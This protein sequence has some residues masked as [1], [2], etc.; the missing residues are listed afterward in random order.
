MNEDTF[1]DD[2]VDM[3]ELA[4]VRPSWDEAAALNIEGDDHR[5]NREGCTEPHDTWAASELYNELYTE[6]S[7]IEDLGQYKKILVVGAGPSLTTAVAEAI[8]YSD[9]DAILLTLPVVKSFKHLLGRPGVYV[10]D[11]EL[12]QFICPW[13]YGEE[14]Y[15]HIRMLCATQKIILPEWHFKELYMW[16]RNEGEYHPWQLEYWPRTSGA[17]AL[18][19]AVEVMQAEVIDHIGIDLSGAY[20]AWINETNQWL[21]Q[22]GVQR[23]HDGQ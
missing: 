9:Y 12:E 2:M 23:W 17:A 20:K 11:A 14:L 13:F 15:P 7:P 6:H 3:S 16:T 10:V 5:L 22:P 8:D 19:I 18:R 4:T 21:A 1:T